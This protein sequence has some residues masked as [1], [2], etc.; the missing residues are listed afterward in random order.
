MDS[1]PYKDQQNIDPKRGRN[2]S[3][4]KMTSGGDDSDELYEQGKY[5]DENV[6]KGVVTKY[7][8]NSLE[9]GLE[10]GEQPLPILQ[11]VS[12]D[13]SLSL[14]RY[15]LNSSNIQSFALTM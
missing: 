13:G 9:L 1:S 14:L 7:L 4:I 15:N 3:A 6:K 8:M 11:K 2:E 5:T 10:R 12:K